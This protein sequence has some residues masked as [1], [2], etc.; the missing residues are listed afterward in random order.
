MSPT[1]PAPAIILIVED[2]EDS[3]DALGQIVAALRHRAIPARDGREALTCLT[4]SRPDLILSDLK[5]PRMDGFELMAAL[6]RNPKLRDLRVVAVTA[7]GDEA[8]LRRTWDAGFAGHLPKPIDFDA[9]AATL[10]R[11]SG[12]VAKTRSRRDRGPAS[13]PRLRR[14]MVSP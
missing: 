13:P 1:S 10:D 6:R 8:T 2:H 4:T 14:P 5:M 7:F 12:G 3:R 11:C 9:V